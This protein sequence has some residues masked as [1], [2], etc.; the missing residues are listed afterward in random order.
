MTQKPPVPVTVSTFALD[1]DEPEN[2]RQINHA[3][4]MHRQWL[5]K[6]LFWAM[7]SGRA[8]TIEP[9]DQVSGGD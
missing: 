4:P 5:D 1:A 9:V 8:V 3:D 6:H 2:E 7:R